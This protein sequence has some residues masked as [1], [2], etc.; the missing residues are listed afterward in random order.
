MPNDWLTVQ[1][2]GR[3]LIEIR[4]RCADDVILRA[5][6]PAGRALDCLRACDSSTALLRSL[7]DTGERRFRAG[8]DADANVTPIR[9]LMTAGAVHSDFSERTLRGSG[10]AELAM[11]FPEA[12]CAALSAGAS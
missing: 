8:D 6:V 11:V 9:N 12:L 5:V 1:V 4:V 3:D 2:L 10:W 7:D